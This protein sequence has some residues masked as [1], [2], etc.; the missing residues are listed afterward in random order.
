[1]KKIY[2]AFLFTCSVWANVYAQN[3]KLIGEEKWVFEKI[4]AYDKNTVSA[5]NAQDVADMFVAIKFGEKQVTFFLPEDETVVMAYT[6]QEGNLV[7]TESSKKGTVD[8]E[9]YEE[10]KKFLKSYYFSIDQIDTNHFRL[11]YW[12]S[13]NGGSKPYYQL[14][15]KK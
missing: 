9:E 2:V 10:Y 4:L 1:M 12:N 13:H 11:N 15:F 14:S 7:L 3:S 6:Y 5:E 8:K